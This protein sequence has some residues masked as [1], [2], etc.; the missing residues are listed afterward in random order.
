MSTLKAQRYV[1]YSVNE[2]LP[3]PEVHFVHEGSDGYLWFCTDR[4]VSRYDGDKFENFTTD[5]GLTYNTVFKVFESPQ[6]NLWFTCH[7]GSLSIYLKEEQRFVPFWGNKELQSMVGSQ[8]VFSVGFKEGDVYLPLYNNGVSF[9]YVLVNSLDSTLTMK[10]FPEKTARI[11]YDN[12]TLSFSRLNEIAFDAY[13]LIY[14]NEA[15]ASRDDVVYEDK[16]IFH[17]ASFGDETLICYRNGYV[18]KKDGEP[19][20]GDFSKR[21]TCATKDR[22]GNYWLTTVSDGVYKIPSF[23]FR[24]FPSNT[25]LGPNEKFVSIGQFNNHLICGSNFGT[26]IGVNTKGDFK[27]LQPNKTHQASSVK[28]LVPVEDGLWSTGGTL[29]GFGEDFTSIRV[30]QSKWPRR[31]FIKKLQNGEYI[32]FGAP[33]AVEITTLPDGLD[34]VYVHDSLNVIALHETQEGDIYLSTFN[35]LYL[36]K[37]GRFG[38]LLAIGDAYGL[39]GKTVRKITSFDSMSVFAT[40]GSGVVLVQGAYFT[41]V[42]EADGLSSNLVNDVLIKDKGRTIFCGTDKGI[43]K[44]ELAEEHGKIVVEDITNLDQGEGMAS[45]FVL[46]I[47]EFDHK[48]WAITD[49]GI[50]NF[51]VNFELPIHPAPMVHINDLEVNGAKFD[52]KASFSYKENTVKINYIGISTK[53][54]S[55]Q[56][57]YKCRILRNEE[58]SDWTHTD[59]NSVLLT[60]LLP[61]EYIFQVS[62][63]ATNSDWAPAECISFTITPYWLSRSTVQIS[64]AALLLVLAVFTYKNRISKLKSRQEKEITLALLNSKVNELELAMLRGQMNPH[65]VYNALQSIQKFVLTDNKWSANKLITRFGKLMRSSLEYSRSDFIS[66]GQEV[67]F[68]NNYFEIETQRFPDRFSYRVSTEMGEQGPNVSLPPLI[69]QPICENAIKHSFRDKLVHISVTFSVE[70]ERA[71]RVIISDNGIGYLNSQTVT[72]PLKK[73]FGLH[74]VKSRI[75]LLKEQG[76]EAG[77]SIDSLNRDTGNGT[78]VQLILPIK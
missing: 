9:N 75:E 23:D 1:N 33:N 48:I 39:L 46:R 21:Y 70:N 35:E 59:H 27:I 4:G 7:D 56:D 54:P 6:G 49:L 58:P 16:E 15:A 67:D 22:E 19:I 62:A 24:F 32:S 44:I 36:L 71:I 45:S 42:K 25:L 63:Q 29:L 14:L 76:R 43:S 11:K 10:S 52:D 55:N 74:I 60:S 31:S 64:F 72:K 51:D 61:G 2:G 13:Q 68:L 65:F 28:F 53:H 34:K 18:R 41:S 66:V 73:S 12:Y 50:C 8:W 30:D 38:E 47:E 26:V 37:K 5:E 57:F 40:S 69:I 20:M 3:S 17:I 77:F 78:V